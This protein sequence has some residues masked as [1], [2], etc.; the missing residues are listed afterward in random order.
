VEQSVG[1]KPDRTDDE[2]NE[3]G[4]IDEPT[5]ATDGQAHLFSTLRPGDSGEAIL[6]VNT[7]KQ[8]YFYG[9]V[10]GWL[11]L[12]VI[13][14]TPFPWHYR[15]AGI[16]FITVGMMTLNIFNPMMGMLIGS[17]DRGFP[18]ELTYTVLL[19]MII[20]VLMSCMSCVKKCSCKRRE[21]TPAASSQENTEGGN[22]HE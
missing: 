21:Q 20:W 9:W 12:F 13:V 2:G 22:S 11:V 1:Q 8:S 14:A 16:A 10:F 18:A 19:T 5:F 7:K 6:K 3:H 15:L 4:N 17:L